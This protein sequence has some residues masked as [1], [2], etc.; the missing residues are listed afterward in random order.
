MNNC[1]DPVGKIVAPADRAPDDGSGG[2]LGTG[3]VVVFDQ[4]MTDGV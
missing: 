2:P 1:L 3:P 4:E